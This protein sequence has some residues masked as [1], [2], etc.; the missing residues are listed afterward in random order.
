MKTASPL[1]LQLQQE[2]LRLQKQIL[3]L[4]LISAGFHC[5]STLRE[6]NW[7]RKTTGLYIDR[8]Q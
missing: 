4:M 1:L 2:Q 6:E 3:I 8:R 7:T 5:A